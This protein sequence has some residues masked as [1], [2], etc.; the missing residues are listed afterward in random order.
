ML[1]TKRTKTLI[2]AEL[3]KKSKIIRNIYYDEEGT[4]DLP[5]ELMDL[6]EIYEEY[7][8]DDETNRLELLF[9]FNPGKQ[10]RMYISG[11]AG[12]GKSY[13]IA[14]LL[15]EYVRRRTD[16]KIFLFSQ[17]PQDRD[18]DNVVAKHNLIEREAFFRVD[19]N[20]FIQPKKSK[21]LVVQSNIPTME[22][23]KRSLCIFDD[24][25][26]IPDDGIKKSIDKLKDVIIATGRDH[27]YQGDDIDIIIT[28]HQILG[29]KRT[30]EI[31]QQA[32]FVVLF[33]QGLGSHGI[34]TTCTKYLNMED[35]HV[36]KILSLN[37]AHQYAIVH[38]EYPSFV[39]EQKKIWLIK[40]KS[41]DSDD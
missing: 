21:K 14:Q 2:C 18:I 9:H 35:E 12:V 41:D 3:D 17:V 37:K 1:T 24:I 34:R 6:L 5:K 7:E 11:Q 29:G 25:D 20:L 27:T 40:K 33:P 16:R 10:L 26:K 28:N 4:S 22:Q 19:L 8:V 13:L 31:V 15:E 32:N 30:S 36:E 38:R 39:L 23:F